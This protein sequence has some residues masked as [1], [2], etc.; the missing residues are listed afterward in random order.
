[1]LSIQRERTEAM[2]KSEL[3][4]AGAFVTVTVGVV[5][6]AAW[7]ALGRANQLFDIL[8]RP[9]AIVLGVSALVIC[10]CT[11]SISAA[12]RSVSSRSHE[13]RRRSERL[14]VYDALLAT[15]ETPIDKTTIVPP[16]ARA[17]LLIGSTPVVNEYRRLVQLRLLGSVD[18]ACVRQQINR[19]LLAMRRDIGEST[20]GLDSEDW[21]AWVSGTLTQSAIESSH[22]SSDASP[23][24]SQIAPAHYL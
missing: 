15:V 5:V 9:T 23:N 20:V 3:V 8:D 6:A 22:A 7:L 14:A 16:A 1:M 19:L 4:V 12:I 18:Q 2:R 13:A 24:F 17:M 21:S 11:L 10:L